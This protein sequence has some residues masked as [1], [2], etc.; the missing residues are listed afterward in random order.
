[1]FNPL[2]D[3]IFIELSTGKTYKVHTLVALLGEQ[4]YLPQ[5]D[6]EPNKALF[7][8]NFL[9]MNALFQLQDELLVSG[10]YL[11]IDSMSI[12]LTA[13]LR[14]ELVINNPLKDYYLDWHNYDTSAQE[15]EDLLTQFWQNIY[16]HEPA[17]TLTPEELHNLCET[18]QLPYPFTH[19]QLQKRWRQLALIHHPDK[20]PADGEVFKQC[21]DEYLTL[22][23]AAS[24]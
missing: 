24:D 5:L 13:T 15:I 11:H 21:H 8:K 4:G 1:M 3:I 19:K 18:W 9:V 22:K 23:S 17:L 7:K 6:N 16:R 14:K 20:N 2:L 12:Y 10:Q